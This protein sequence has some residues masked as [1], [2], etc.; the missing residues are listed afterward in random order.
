MSVAFCCLLA[1]LF[2]LASSISE[3]TERA[4]LAV[5]GLIWFIIGG[6]I[7]DPSGSKPDE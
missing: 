5:L 6:V 2:W 1:T 3:G 7:G 4:T